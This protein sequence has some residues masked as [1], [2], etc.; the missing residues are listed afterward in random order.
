MSIKRFLGDT[1]R[2]ITALAAAVA[3]MAAGEWLT[4]QARPI[5]ILVGAYIFMASVVLLIAWRES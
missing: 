4:H 2:L 1:L 3:V 5:V